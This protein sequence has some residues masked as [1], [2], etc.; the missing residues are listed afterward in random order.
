L[1]QKEVQELENY[2]FNNGYSGLL[3]KKGKLIKDFAILDMKVDQWKH[4]P[5]II[6][7]VLEIRGAE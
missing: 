4:T 6:T 3:T 2:L 7:T 1:G 5:S